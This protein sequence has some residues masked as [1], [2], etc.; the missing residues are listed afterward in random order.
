[1]IGNLEIPRQ[2]STH[3]NT[4]YNTALHIMEVVIKDQREE[5]KLEHS[6]DMH[7]FTIMII[8]KLH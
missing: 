4:L 8:D 1:M 3:V 2:L 7:Q 6:L 5:R